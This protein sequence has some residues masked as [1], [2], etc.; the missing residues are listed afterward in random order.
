MRAALLPA[1]RACPRSRPSPGADEGARHRRR[2]ASSARTSSTSWSTAGHEPRILDLVPSPYHAPGEVETVIG[3]LDRRGG[4]ARGASSGC[5]AIFHLAAMAD[6]NQVVERPGAH[7]RAS[8]SAAPST[9]SRRRARPRARAVPLR[10]HG[11]GVRQRAR[12]P[13]RTTRTR[14]S[15]CRRTSTRRRSS[16]G[17]MYCRAYETLYGVSDDDPPLRHPVRA[18]RPP[19]RGRPGVH[20]ARRRRASR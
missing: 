16:P 12:A 10:E 20:R 7:R 1:G 18:A 6:V 17:E 13:S 3:D 11:L 19:G 9:C 14:R 8:T 5:D 4:R 15:S 2:R